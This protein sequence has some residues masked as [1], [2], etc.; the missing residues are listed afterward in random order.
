MNHNAAAKITMLSIGA[1]PE[2][3]VQR[4]RERELNPQL[5]TVPN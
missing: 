2:F 4:E 1:L 5:V 3:Q